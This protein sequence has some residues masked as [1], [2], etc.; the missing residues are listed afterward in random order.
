LLS[1]IG[2]LTACGVEPR[3]SLNSQ[4]SAPS[5]IRAQD[6]TSMSF[7]VSGARTELART[8]HFTTVPNA[9]YRRESGA[10]QLALWNRITQ[11]VNRM[12]EQTWM[13]DPQCQARPNG[14]ADLY[15]AIKVK[16]ENGTELDLVTPKGGKYCTRSV[17]LESANQLLIAI[18][19]AATAARLEGCP[20]SMFTLDWLDIDRENERP[21]PIEESPEDARPPRPHPTPEHS[22][23]PYPTAQPSWPPEPEH[24]HRQEHEQKGKQE[25]PY[26]AW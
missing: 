3:S 16:R 22:P 11:A 1:L 8:G 26:R 7:V 9:C 13:K 17:D 24:E 15:Q 23:H 5:L 2:T 4:P 20:R 25:S 21:E 18:A 19:E 10:L 14:S 12:L 6:W